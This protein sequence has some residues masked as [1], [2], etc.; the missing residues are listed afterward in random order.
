MASPKKLS[1][2]VVEDE[3][4]IRVLL[5]DMI[6]ELGHTIAGQAARVDEALALVNSPLAFDIA[7]LDVN[8]DGKTVEPIAAAIERRGLPFLLVTGYGESEIPHRFRGRPFLEKP[9]A[10][11]NL[12]DILQAVTRR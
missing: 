10:V 11:A 5:C 4:I 3:T 1:V 12:L 9:F 7:I 6:E 2:L 8:L